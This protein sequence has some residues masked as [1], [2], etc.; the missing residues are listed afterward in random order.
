M[1][2]RCLALSHAIRRRKPPSCRAQDDLRQSAIALAPTA[3]RGSPGSFT[4]GSVV[5]F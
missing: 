3:A 4:S 1:D 2:D 5:V